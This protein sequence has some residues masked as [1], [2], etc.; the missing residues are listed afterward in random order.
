MDDRLKMLSAK[1]GRMTSAQ[2]ADWLIETYPVSGSEYG[3]AIALMPHRS[4]KRPDQVRL[5]RHYLQKMP[6]ANSKPY[7]AFGSFM[8][9]DLFLK[10]LREQLPCNKA[11]VD[12]LLYHLSPVM[13][14]LAKNDADRES[15][16]SFIADIE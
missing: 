10:M 16:K 15:M 12:L 14:R 8:S 6:F 9:F 1:L 4:W 11:D 2:A 3:E 13:S 5:A 7:E